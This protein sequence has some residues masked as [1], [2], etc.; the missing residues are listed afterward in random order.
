[1]IVIM[2]HVTARE[3]RTKSHFNNTTKSGMAIF[4]SCPKCQLRPLTVKF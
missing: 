1:M 4:D 3:S 2:A